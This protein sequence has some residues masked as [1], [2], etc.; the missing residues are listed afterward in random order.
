MKEEKE[1]YYSLKDVVNNLKSFLRFLRKKWLWVLVAV[2]AGAGLGAVYFNIQKPKYEAVTTFI[3]E[4]KS[5]GGGGLA[6]LASQF[7]FN[8]GGL[9]AGG[10]I[11]SG[12]N[13]LDILKSKKI[14]EQ[15]LLSKID[16]TKPGD[17]TLADLYL[18]FTGIKKSWR[19]K[20]ELADISFGKVQRQ[21]DPVQDSILN[22]IY[23]VIVKKYLFTERTT[24][25]GSIIR[26]K[27]TAPD[28][29]FARLMTERLVEEAGKMY[30]T[31]R[32]GNAQEN[33]RQLQGR[34]DSLLML[35]NNKSFSTAA[36]QPLD[37]NPGIRTAIVPVEI[38]SRDKTVLAT[39]YAEVTKNL[40]ASKV[41]LSQQ[42]PVIELLDQPGYLL[43]NNKKGLLFLLVVFS[44][45]GGFIYIMGA[46]LSFLF[47]G[48]GSTRDI[49][50]IDDKRE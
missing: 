25:Q 39:L 12:D 43:V 33:I 2:T 38:A 8:L 16:N 11:F 50:N 28:C 10:S 13:I 44:M 1:G 20:P 34:S 4:E 36:M 19:K 32:V 9:G 30:M 3:L 48:V 18:E 35:L 5:S 6:G 7:G 29:V 37:I 23:E 49:N 45:A 21:I 41:L 27:V 47:F 22:V 46:F 40:E 14:M 31:I 26:V 15:V 42:T 24:K 17:K